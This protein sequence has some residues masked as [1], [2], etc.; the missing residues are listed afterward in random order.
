MVSPLV[1]ISYPPL[2]AFNGSTNCNT[3]ST[4][5][6]ANFLRSF[7][8]FLSV[9]SVDDENATRNRR[10]ACACVAPPQDFKP[11]KFVVSVHFK[12]SI[13]HQFLSL[14]VLF[15]DVFVLSPY[16]VFK[17]GGWVS[18]FLVSYVYSCCSSSLELWWTVWNI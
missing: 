12:E 6:V 17:F 8:T 2:N 3:R 1:S 14:I 7:P 4:I 11:A 18:L 15:F 16:V 5:T 13:F 9:S 10:V